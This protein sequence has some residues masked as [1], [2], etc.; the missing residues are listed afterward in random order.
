MKNARPQVLVVDDELL[1][2]EILVEHL[3]EENYRTV[4]AQDGVEAWNLLEKGPEEFD[5]V[6]LDRMMPR[7]DG[8]E[9]LVRMKA[10]NVLKMVPVIIQTAK[11]G[12][13]DILEGLQAGASYYLTKPFEKKALLAILKTAISDHATYKSLQD[14]LKKTV[15]S[16]GLMAMGR[17]VFRTMEEGFNLATLL[18][19][20]CPSPATVV[21]GL[22]E[23]LFNA[24][25]H[26][27]LGITY[28]DKS[29]LNEL[30]EWEAEVERRQ[31]L[32]ENAEKRVIVQVERKDNEIRFLVRDQGP[33]FDW[34]SYL[35]ISPERVFDSHGRGI[36][37]ARKFSFE[38]LEYN[39]KGNE[40]LG[41]VI[42]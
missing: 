35:E 28:E 22:S 39:D 17:F 6:L 33:G 3:E 13:Q 27:N 25:E 10:H 14:E 31:A 4:T 23:L 16:L 36:A 32:P 41:V 42:S 21:L 40:V 2:L 1:N 20:A 18:A 38:R 29:R 24:V 19:N 7:M 15:G 9:V 34:Q 8:M 12:K 30:G 37:L 11:A 5:A 26:G